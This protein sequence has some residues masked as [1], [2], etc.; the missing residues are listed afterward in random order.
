METV[1]R[2]TIL[3][4][5]GRGGMSTVYKAM[6]P[7][8]GRI[9]ALKILRPRDDIFA[10]LV[11][12]ERL[13]EMFVEEARIMGEI[14]HEHVAT[15]L[16]CDEN[17]GAPFI[18]LEYFS[19]SLGDMIGEAYRVEDRSR[20]LSVQRSCLYLLQAL[21]GLERLHFAGIVHRDIKPYNL[22]I[23][24]DDRVKIIDFGLS[25]VRGEEPMAI[26]GMQV[27]SPYYSAPEQGTSPEAADGRADLYSLGVM[28][29][30]MLTGCLVESRT[31]IEL[32]SRLNR[33]LDSSWDDFLLK[34]LAV[35]PGE[36]FADATRMRVELEQLFDEWKSS[37]ARNCGIE[38]LWSQEVGDNSIQLRSEPCRIMYKDIRATLELDELFRPTGFYR[39]QLV[40]KS[41]LLLYDPVTGLYWQRSGTG[42]TLN[43]HQAR[44]YV[45]YLNETAF[46]GHSG[47]R[48]PTT[49]ELVTV[50]RSPTATRDFCIDPHFASSLHWL[51][52][53]DHCTKKAAWM[54]DIVESY[55][56]RL[57][58]DGAAS[59]CAVCS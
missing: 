8:T 18:V 9:V 30:R 24:S 16:D 2:Y 41:P 34:T 42:F 23:T 36:R 13:R 39:H 37:S 12:A 20:R 6:A 59:V 29:Y 11:G 50:L 5:L 31:E 56:G 35:E 3:G 49:A 54:A 22:M 17:E 1:G 32:P 26:P 21:K 25:R 46:A 55:I 51:W 14:D 40:V 43:W 27:G 47:W 45:H 57:D 28:M 38:N 44:D 10:D 15:I 19:H 4:R 33:E 48:L 58:M 53:A 52:S 7:V